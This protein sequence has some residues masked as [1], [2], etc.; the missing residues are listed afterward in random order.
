MTTFPI[1]TETLARTSRQDSANR[2][3]RARR[4]REE[5]ARRQTVAY[6]ESHGGSCEHVARLLGIPR[7]TVAHWQQQQHTSAATCRPRGR[8]CQQSPLETRCQVLQT[9][10]ELGPHVGLPTLR[11]AHSQLPRVELIELQAGYRAHFRATH[12]QQQSRLTWLRP[13]TVWAMDHSQP[14]QW[15]D[16]SY[17]DVFAVRDLASGY[18]LLWLPV[19]DA[20]TRYVVDLLGSLFEKHGAPLV[21]KCDNGSALRSQPVHDLLAQWEVIELPSPPHTPQYNGSCEAGIHSMKIRTAY[22]ALRVGCADEWRADH[23][24]AGRRQANDVHHSDTHLALTAGE[25]WC[26]RIN[27][28]IKERE[29][30]HALVSHYRTAIAESTLLPNTTIDN[31]NEDSIHRCAVSQALQRLG[32]LYLESRFITPAIK[33]NNLAKIM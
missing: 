4:E 1:T 24:E 8:P 29:D 19:P 22:F 27:I 9:L 3:Q 25:R 15:I 7:R 6:L 28:D 17:S 18:Q 33:P 32:F 31:N 12:P 20:S 14:P 16:G 11:A 26:Q 23:L 21:L 2:R 30:L 5:R 13:G 10:D